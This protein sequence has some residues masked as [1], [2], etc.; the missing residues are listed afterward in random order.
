MRMAKPLLLA[1]CAAALASIADPA[2]AQVTAKFSFDAVANCERP[3]MVR[4]FPIHGEGTGTLSPDRTATLDLN[5]NVEGMQRYDAKLGGKA[6]ETPDGFAT[7]RVR[8]R[9]SLRAI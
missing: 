2:L 1:G 9:R 5:S 4:N 7:L 6:I 8:S 3:M